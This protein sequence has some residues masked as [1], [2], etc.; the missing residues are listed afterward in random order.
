MIDSVKHGSGCDCHFSGG[1][2]RPGGGRTVASFPDRYT[3]PRA[4][5]TRARHRGFLKVP[6]IRMEPSRAAPTARHLRRGAG[7]RVW[8]AAKPACLVCTARS[9]SRGAPASQDAEPA[10]I[11]AAKTNENGNKFRAMQNAREQNGEREPRMHPGSAIQKRARKRP[12][13]ARQT[14]TP[15]RS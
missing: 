5:G 3:P 2:L 1:Q 14:K 15:R 7:W 13:T 8:V 6:A 4:Y 12:E 11:K 10:H 9:S